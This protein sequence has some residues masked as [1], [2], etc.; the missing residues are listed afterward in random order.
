MVVNQE[1]YLGP[2]VVDP[3]KF[4]KFGD[5]LPSLDE[6][7]LTPHPGSC[8]PLPSTLV[9]LVSRAGLG[10]MQAEAVNC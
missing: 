9:I 7:P 2:S 1:T 6:Q 8:P 5:D 4:F 3:H 10:V